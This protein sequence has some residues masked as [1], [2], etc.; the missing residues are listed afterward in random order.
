MISSLEI[1]ILYYLSNLINI[2][3]LTNYFYSFCRCTDPVITEGE[4]QAL[5]VEHA[6]RSLFVQELLLNTLGEQFNTEEL[7]SLVKVIDLNSSE[8]SSSYPDVNDNHNSPRRDPVSAIPPDSSPQPQPEEVRQ[9]RAS[10]PEPLRPAP[11]VQNR[12]A[13]GNSFGSS[14]NPIGRGSSGSQRVPSREALSSG[15]R[16]VNRTTTRERGS[17]PTRRKALRQVDDRNK[18]TEPPPPH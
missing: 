16:P 2:N 6:E 14:N 11:R 8:P 12:G 1:K 3:L 9:P 7:D 18:T 4:Q 17:S 10:N 13:S 15:A 5:E